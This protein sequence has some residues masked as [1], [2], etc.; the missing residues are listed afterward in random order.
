MLC[1][2]RPYAT[3]HYEHYFE[4]PYPG[5]K[6]IDH[7][8]IPDFAS[9]AMENLGLITY[10]ETALLLDEKTAT[11]AE[12]N[13]VAVVVLHELAHMWFGDLVTMDWW[14]GLWLNE[15]FATFM[16]NLCLS[17]WKPEWNIWDEF[18]QSRAMASRVDALRSARTR[19]KA[20]STIPMTPS[21]S[22]T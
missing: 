1:R 14:N 20:R 22:S 8:A 15:S 7:I 9:G 2:R 21:N 6:K 5:G 19:L 13:R 11:H 10:R 12:R 4:I 17:H 18:G 3:N 16:E